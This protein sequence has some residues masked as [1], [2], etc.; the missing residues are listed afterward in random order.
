MSL[1]IKILLFTILFIFSNSL[2]YA[3]PDY[4][5]P[6]D[7][8]VQCSNTKIHQMTGYGGGLIVNGNRYVTSGSSEDGSKMYYVR[9]ETNKYG[10]QQV[11][12]ISRT[13]LAYK[14]NNAYAFK[15]VFSEYGSDDIIIMNQCYEIKK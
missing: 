8:Y 12:K 3:L 5:S 10:V 1:Q 15:Y 2:L 9:I 6:D 14:V 13:S 4:T 11:Y 7:W